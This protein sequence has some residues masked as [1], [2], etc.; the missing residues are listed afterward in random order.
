MIRT[1]VLCVVIVLSTVL[2][3]GCGDGKAKAKPSS[4]DEPAVSESELSEF[5]NRALPVAAAAGAAMDALGT[6]GPTAADAIQD[7]D[8]SAYTDALETLDSHRQAVLDACE[9]ASAEIEQAGDLPDELVRLDS[10]LL[11]LCVDT[12]TALR[13]MANEDAAGADHAITRAKTNAIELTEQLEAL[14]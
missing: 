7:G 3:G 1:T 10:L 6:A 9:P 12:S 2:A 11:S 13:L 4:N 14:S 8:V 5:R